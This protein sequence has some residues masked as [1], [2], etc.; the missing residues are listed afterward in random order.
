MIVVA[1]LGFRRATPAPDICA[2]IAAALEHH[3]LAQ[4]GLRCLATE[5]AKAREPGIKEAADK[6]RLP[7]IE[8]SL[9]D[10]REAGAR[11]L[12][13]SLRVEALKG[14]PSIAETAAL[15]AAGCEA[16]L[17]G[18]RIAHDRAT[19]AL[20]FHGTPLEGVAS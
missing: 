11:T 16:R 17:L 4:H 20:A 13:H 12:T 18:P 6:L 9:S 14:V 10:L 2:V 5:S 8:C 19:C 7:L 1:G 15:V 3:G